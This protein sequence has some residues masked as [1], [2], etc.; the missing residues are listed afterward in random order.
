MRSTDASLR[1]PE[2][3]SRGFAS[4]SS[5]RRHWTVSGHRPDRSSSVAAVS[6]LPPV[7]AITAALR[8]L[9]PAPVVSLNSVLQAP[10]LAG[11]RFVPPTQFISSPRPVGHLRVPS[12]PCVVSFRPPPYAMVCSSSIAFRSCPSDTDLVAGNGSTLSEYVT[13]LIK[14]DRTLGVR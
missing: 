3:G 5:L 4:A 7:I 10:T 9:L 12:A 14:Y 8:H 13:L 1:Y 6:T 2:C 11:P